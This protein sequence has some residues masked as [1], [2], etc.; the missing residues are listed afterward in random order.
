MSFFGFCLNYSAS[1]P[2]RDAILTRSRHTKRMATYQII[3]SGDGSG[4]NIGVAGSNG[5]RQTMLGFT[6]M[7]EAEAWIVQDR[8]LTDGAEYQHSDSLA[9]Q[10]S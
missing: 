1:R 4:F 3:P 2:V 8:R 9:E 5:A 6:S 10:N 7:E